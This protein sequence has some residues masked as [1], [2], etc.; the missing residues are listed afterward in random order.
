M[1]NLKSLIKL[2]FRKLYLS[3]RDRRLNS[4]LSVLEKGVEVFKIYDFG[5]VTRMRANTFEVKEPETLSW[6]KGFDSDDKLLDIG[7]NIGIYS[8]YAASKGIDVVAIEPDALNYALLNLNIRINQLGNKIIPYSIAVHDQTYFSKFNISS[9][10]WGGALNSFDNSLDYSGKRY[11]P[12]HSQGVFGVSLDSFL[13]Q[14]SFTPSHIKIDVDGNENL[15]L[16]GASNFL[17]N[18]SLK[19]ILIELDENRKDYR[20]SINSLEKKGFK[21]LEKKVCELN[22]KKFNS[23]YNHIFVRSN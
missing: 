13:E 10:K 11:K 14:I 4:L 9:Y 21:I 19:S 23:T 2:L 12:V 22:N 15:I 5:P 6:I 18:N 20:E 17:M 7:A 8:L 16:E 3:F 1:D